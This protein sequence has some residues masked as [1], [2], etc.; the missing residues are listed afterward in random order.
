VGVA[1]AWYL[2]RATDQWEMQGEPAAYFRLLAPDFTP[3]P[4]YNAMR[5]YIASVADH[6][7]VRASAQ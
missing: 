4:V 6:V 1:N 5:Q 2:K 3:Q 7:R